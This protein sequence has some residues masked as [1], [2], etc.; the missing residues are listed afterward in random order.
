MYVKI[1]SI[2]FVTF[3]LTNYLFCGQIIKIIEECSKSEDSKVEKGDTQNVQ[4]SQAISETT[5]DLLSSLTLKIDPVIISSESTKLKESNQTIQ[6]WKL[7]PRVPLDFYFN[8]ISYIFSTIWLAK[9]KGID[10]KKL[11]D[12]CIKLGGLHTSFTKVTSLIFFRDALDPFKNNENSID[13]QTA[14]LAGAKL[15]FQ[16]DVEEVS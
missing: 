9:A 1:I 12:Q 11:L 4:K 3:V 14:V 16:S 5:K 13:L 8:P 6:V 2:V 7:S 10:K 15:L